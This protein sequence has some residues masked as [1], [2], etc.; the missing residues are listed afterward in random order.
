MALKIAR[1]RLPDK[2]ARQHDLFEEFPEL[3][4]VIQSLDHL[5]PFLFAHFH[6]PVTFPTSHAFMASM[7]ATISI[8]A[9]VDNPDNAVTYLAWR[10]GIQIGHPLTILTTFF[11][12]AVAAL[13]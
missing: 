1:Q 9:T 8:E 11:M 12:P 13:A 3:R 10:L 2:T 7:D 6:R 5:R 4:I